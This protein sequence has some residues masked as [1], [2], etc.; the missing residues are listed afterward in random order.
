MVPK[1]RFRNFGNPNLVLGLLYANV[2]GMAPVS[3]VLSGLALRQFRSNPS[4][5]GKWIARIAVVV[6][7]LGTAA[8]VFFFFIVIAITNP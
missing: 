2:S 1:T 3:L 6:G 4:L 8:F 5:H 7:T